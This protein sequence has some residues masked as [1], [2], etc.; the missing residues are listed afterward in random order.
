MSLRA[1]LGIPAEAKRAIIFAE[2]SH[3]D[4]NWRLTSE[5][6]F[7]RLVG[8]NLDKAVGEL[9]KEPRRVFSAECVFFLRMYWDRRPEKRDDVRS[10]VNEGRLRLTSSGVTTADTLLPSAEVILRDM[11]I[12][13]EWLRSNGMSQEPKVAYFPDSFGSSPAL[14]ALL[15]AAGIGMAAVTRIDGMLSASSYH[16]VIRKRFP[17]PQSTAALLMRKERCADFV[18]RGPD[19]SEI[20]CHWNVHDYRQGDMLA[21]RGIAR[22]HEFPVGI[23]DHS[24]WNVSGKVRHFVR[25]L[26]PY[27]R[28]PYLFCP[29]GGDFI[30]TIP[31][32]VGLLDRY[33]RIHYPKAGTWAVNA[34]LDDYLALVNCHRDLL[35]VLEIDPNPCWMGFYASRPTLKR[36]CHE[37]VDRLLLA[38]RLALLPENQGQG[39]QRI[40]ALEEAWW[41]AA[42]S[43]H[44]DFITGTAPDR[45]V[46]TEQEPWL[47][48]GIAEAN[49]AIEE[50]AP[51]GVQAASV[52]PPPLPEWRR[53]GDVLEISTPH[54]VIELAE[55]KGG[56]IARA[57]HP[58]TGVPLL[59]AS[60]YLV[61]YRDTGGLW[62]MGHEFW[63]GS[64]KET[65]RS[66]DR[67]AAIEVADLD[68]CLEAV[69]T[70]EVDG[71]IIRQVY[72]FRS[73]TPAISFRVGGRA[74]DRRTVAVRFGTGLAP[75]RLA[76]DAPGGVVLRPLERIYSPTFWPAQSFVH[77]QDGAGGRGMAMCLSVPGAVS[78]RPDGILELVALRNATSERAFGFLP[79][80][81]MTVTGHETS[82]H[83]CEYALLFTE[84][85]GWRESSVPL[86]AGEVLAW[87]WG[88][89]TE[90]RLRG[91]A[92]SL[93]TTS[94]AEVI[95]TAVKPASRGSG[96][97]V[98]L[99]SY[100]PAGLAVDVNVRAFPVKA[101]FLCDARERDLEPLQIGGQNVRLTMPGAIAS[102]RLVG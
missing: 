78:C 89:S 46:R 50:L 22:V 93:V 63:G 83:V 18:W 28:T 51:R 14:P 3:W 35:P 73:D 90:A 55:N 99:Y 101:A 71:Q 38:E 74:A 12:G 31:G 19:G 40:K 67:P 10:L 70:V 8:P 64:L 45:V 85:G 94:Q 59:S 100:L 66:S 47:D 27:S 16:E 60:N 2:S 56:S 4:P 29:I 98:R 21:H 79:L 86:K 77:L 5:E 33:N 17:R 37:L 23:A 92:G 95:V 91:L 26:T 25:R 41:H 58:V 15:K 9:L 69:C 11:L 82:E 13:Q 20:L 54:Y 39:P 42:A 80:L 87:L 24:D 36:K 84:S 32:L 34:G 81:G 48:R 68:G 102:V 65:A 62:R 97:M 6:Y 52:T 53:R 61:S 76:M 44:H 7:E 49:A 1:R 96:I 75:S 88:S 30:D 57:W 72:R 43:N